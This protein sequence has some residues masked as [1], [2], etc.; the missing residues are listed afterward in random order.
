VIPSRIEVNIEEVKDGYRGRTYRRFT[1]KKYCVYSHSVDGEIFYI[2][3]GTLLRPLVLSGGGSSYS[4][5]NRFWE[6]VVTK[7]GYFDLKILDWFDSKQEAVAREKELISE[8]KPVGNPKKRPRKPRVN[9]QPDPLKRKTICKRGH[10]LTAET[11]YIN[12]KGSFNCRECIRLRGLT[13]KKK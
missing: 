6:D 9:S 3:C 2:G 5:R 7:Y 13:R 1:Y 11:A 8:Y 10:L 4:G 12:K